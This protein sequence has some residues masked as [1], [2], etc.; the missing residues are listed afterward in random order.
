MFQLSTL[1]KLHLMTFPWSDMVGRSII[2][3]ICQIRRTSFWFQSI[4]YQCIQKDNYH[5]GPQRIW[6]VYITDQLVLGAP[7]TSIRGSVH[8]SVGPLRLLIFGGFGVPLGQNWLLLF[9]TQGLSNNTSHEMHLA[10]VFHQAQWTDRR[11]HPLKRNAR[12]H[13]IKAI[14]GQQVLQQNASISGLIN[15]RDRRT[16]PRGGAQKK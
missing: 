7:T 14:T 13:V 9:E 6:S 11:T 5:L 12:T 1:D 8:P 16:D 2:R 4:R 10:V 3:L 15:M